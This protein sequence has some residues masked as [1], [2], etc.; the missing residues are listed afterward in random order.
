MTSTT[1]GED[2]TYSTLL[3]TPFSIPTYCFTEWLLTDEQY[4]TIS[5]TEEVYSSM[6][7][8]LRIADAH[9]TNYGCS[10]TAMVSDPGWSSHN[11]K[12]CPLGFTTA[13]IAITNSYPVINSGCDTL[14]AHPFTYTD[15]NGGAGGV[16]ETV[17]TTE[18]DYNCYYSTI[19]TIT[20]TEDYC[21]QV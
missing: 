18:T 10:F 12:V 17:T 2:P 15:N 16:L 9:L 19:G 21:C 13:G 5:G 4:N 7:G 14:A 11:A 6:K 8:A 1:A 20:L 3:T